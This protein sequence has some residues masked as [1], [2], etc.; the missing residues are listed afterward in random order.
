MVLGTTTWELT[1]Q[2]RLRIAVVIWGNKI[3]G[4]FLQLFL[5]CRK[6]IHYEITVTRFLSALPYLSGFESEQLA[7][8]PHT[9]LL[10][11]LGDKDLTGMFCL[12]I[13]LPD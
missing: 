9:C 12:C 6:R 2:A 5:L 10:N 13:Y 3:K 8:V 7:D 11:I 1:R 4:K